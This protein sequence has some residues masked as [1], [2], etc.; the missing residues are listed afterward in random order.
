MAVTTD[1]NTELAR[2]AEQWRH[3]E[4]NGWHERAE[5][6]RRRLDVLLDMIPAQRESE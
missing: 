3:A 2:V 5:A 1:L 6:H 4:L